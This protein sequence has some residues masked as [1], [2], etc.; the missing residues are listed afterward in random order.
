M[1]NDVTTNL[2]ND[3]RQLIDSTRAYVA[4]TV[5]SSL[6]LLYWKMG[7]LIHIEILKEERAEYGETIIKQLASQL[8]LAYGRGFSSRAIFRMVRLAKMYPDEQIVTTLS[9]GTIVG[10]LFYGAYSI[11]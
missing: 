1:K 2:F 6:V 10:I 11:R 5:N 3:I 4:Q 9:V 8:T 7:Q